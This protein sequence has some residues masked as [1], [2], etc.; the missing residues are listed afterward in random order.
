[1][2]ITAYSITHYSYLLLESTA[3]SASL[4]N[5][6]EKNSKTY[7]L[8]IYY[9]GKQDNRYERNNEAQ[10][11]QHTQRMQALSNDQKANKPSTQ[12]SQTQR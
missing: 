4:K 8:A 12:R 1:M 7:L 10:D 11:S 2:Y 6:H 5:S 3:L 9:Q